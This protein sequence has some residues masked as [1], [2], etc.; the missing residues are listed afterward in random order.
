MQIGLLPLYNTVCCIA[1]N[2]KED[3][4]M[5]NTGLVVTLKLLYRFGM[6]NLLIYEIHELNCVVGEMSLLPFPPPPKR[7]STAKY[8]LSQDKG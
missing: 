4:G 7:E 1:L 5:I 2:F 6:I 8:L 3:C